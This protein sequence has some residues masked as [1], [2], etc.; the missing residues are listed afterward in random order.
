M[1]NE[2]LLTFKLTTNLSIVW[3]F[4]AITG[5]VKKH[6]AVENLKIKIK[7]TLILKLL[8][9]NLW[10]RMRFYG[11]KPKGIIQ[12]EEN[13]V[14]RVKKLTGLSIVDSNDSFSIIST[15]LYTP[16]KKQSI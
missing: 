1:S 2:S 9:L 11:K 15:M 7:I 4:V 10:I 5:Y 3:K 12:N 8:H 14:E 6:A 16:L 13:L